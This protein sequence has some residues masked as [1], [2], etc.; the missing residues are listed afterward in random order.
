MTLPPI[1][2]QAADS[3]PEITSIV[4]DLRNPLAAIHG[5]AEMLIGRSL[6]PAQIHRIAR[7]V[8]GASMRMQE[9][10][11]EFFTRYR[12]ADRGRDRG[13]DACDLHDMIDSAIAKIALLAESQRVQISRAVQENLMMVL[14]RRRIERVLVNLMVNALDV[15][16]D[17]G[18]IDLSAAVDG[19]YVVIRVRDS[20]PGIPPEIRHRLFQSFATARKAAGLGLGLAISR[21]AVIDHGGDIWVEPVARGACFALSLPLAAYA[22]D[23]TTPISAAPE[24]R[25]AAIA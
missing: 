4:H 20:G 6:S 1:V 19:D 14:D 23:C 3:L 15:M 7:N 5:S 8:Y 12:D 2:E 11:D 9:L 10:L 22:S 13:M 16:P 18:S 21:Q 17:G 25:L 24:K